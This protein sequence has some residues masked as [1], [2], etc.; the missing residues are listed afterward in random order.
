MR[1]EHWLYTIPLRLRSLLRRK[2][3]EQEL[4]EELQYHLQ[5]K[6]EEFLAQ[7]MS[8]EDARRAAVRTIDGLELRKE[9]CRD[10]RGLNL[11][12]TLFQ[13][14]RFGFRMLRKSP[15]FTAVAVLTLA[16]SIGGNT[17]IFSIV[18][19]VLVRGLPFSQQQRLVALFQTPGKGTGIMGWAASGPDIVDWQRY[20]HSFKG[21]AA[22]LQDAANLTGRTSPRHL[23]G[24]KVTTNYFDLLG[25]QASLGRTFARGEEESGQDREVILSYALW[26]EA[27]GGE[28]VLG[29][30]ISLD[31]QPFVVIG[32]MPA[33]YHDPRT[34][35]NP[36]SAYWI[37]LSTAQL[38][39]NRGEHMY[40]VFGRLA[41]GITLAQA[42]EE[43]D[44]IAAR[45]AKEFPNTNEG[46]GARVSLLSEVS[47][48]TFE[49]G[50]FQSVAPAIFLLQ[51]SVGFLL[52]IACANIAN[53]MFSR[54]VSRRTELA[55]RSV[56][57]AGRGRLTGQLLTESALLSLLG[58]GVGVL[59]AIWCKNALLSVAPKGYLPPTANVS[60][61]LGVLGFTLVVAL[62][63]GI[64]FGLPPALRA[65]RQ[66]LGE[67]LKGA[68]TG[69]AQPS[70][71]PRARRAL[72]VFEL[73]ATFLLLV[74]AGLM[75]RSLASLLAVNP[76]FNQRSFFT[77][78]MS[79]SG[80]RYS[81][82]EQIVGFL[83]QVQDRVEKMPDVQA[84]AFTSSPDFI[85]NSSSDVIPEGRAPQP[86][87]LYSQICVITPGFFRATGIPLLAGRDFALADSVGEPKV[88]I[89]SQAFAR[90]FW[91]QQYPLGKHLRCCGMKDSLEVVALAGDVKQNGL[92]APSRPEV[93]FPLSPETSQ[94]PMNIVVRS[95]APPAALAKG[96][97]RQV[98]A[99][100]SLVPLSDIR[101]GDQ[102]MIEWAGY[103]RYRTVLLAS[104]AATALLI[105]V[106]GVF[107]AISYTAAQRTREIGIRMALGAQRR[108]VRWLVLRQGTGLVFIG[109]VVGI[110]GA[111]A[112]TRL[113]TTLLFG[114]KPWDPLTFAGVAILLALVA[115]AACYMPARRAM[116]VDPMV[117]LRNE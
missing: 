47:M 97:E 46:M 72:I 61:D 2:R 15:G 90:Y 14:I 51:L 116:R 36:Q 30:A 37:P 87:D 93:Y 83:S 10:A 54:A 40:A 95:A 80:E 50:K 27:F 107:G 62:L 18:N 6:T 64:V 60:L 44:V 23:A 4:D 31:D 67:E 108:D 32:V 48:Q 91:P 82:P 13:D 63:S 9:Q 73:S 45:E 34:W 33:T 35:M 11:I 99:I 81:K 5:R 94:T 69:G 77:A 55:L 24:Q 70:S 68:A 22:S 96:I 101:T 111:L 104:F 21:I 25:A 110:G 92:A 19:A 59:L 38:E 103:L 109:L 100:D 114:V 43:M 16:L 53:L 7:G 89:V 3:V 17:A 102:L 57:G 65:S 76:G 74:G 49:E 26:Q 84:V 66:N 75:L 79:P 105:A 71:M 113:M 58:G 1:I 86:G 28:N 78:T 115:L 117:A 56:M 52:L 41:S 98:W 85:D 12:E 42:Q 106:I 39:A 88:T 112:L 8:S 29:R 20:S